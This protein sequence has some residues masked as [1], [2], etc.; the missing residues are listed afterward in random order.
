M[1]T[2]ARRKGILDTIADEEIAR[3]DSAEATRQEREQQVVAVEDRHRAVR[4]NIA[5]IADRRMVALERAELAAREMST[6]LA[7]V[8]ELSD[9]IREAAKELGSGPVHSIHCSAF[10]GIRT[11]S[12]AA[13]ELVP[14]LL[15]SRTARA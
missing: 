9:G 11:T 4:A 10:G 15:D 14:H 12:P 2:A 8:L 3:E 5:D 6:Q 13:T 1:T 7:E